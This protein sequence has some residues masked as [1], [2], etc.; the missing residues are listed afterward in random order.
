VV[1]VT[2]GLLQLVATLDTTLV[3]TS[4]P[5]IAAEFNS[6]ATVTWVGTSMLVAQATTL[7]PASRLSDIFGRKQ[8]LIASLLVFALGNL[9]CGF[10]QS[11]AWLYVARGIAGAGAG[12]INS[13]SLIV[14]S[15][16][17]S[18]RDRGKYMSYM[19]IPVALGLGLGPEL[20]GVLADHA[21]WRWAFWITVPL[22]LVNIPVIWW[23]LPLKP[24]PGSMWGKLAS[25]DWFGCGLSLAGIVLVLVPLSA[26]GATIPW[27]SA[28]AIAMLVVGG[29]VLITFL[30]AECVQYSLYV[31]CTDSRHL[32]PLPVLPLR[33]F[34]NRTVA[35]VMATMAHVG[36]VWFGAFFMDPL[37]LQNVQG[38]SAVV[39]G[40]LVLP[41]LVGQIIFMVA[42]GYAMRRWGRT[43]RIII[44]GY[45]IWTLGQGMQV[46]WGVERNV[47][48]VV[49]STFVQ[50][51][52]FGLTSQ[53]SKRKPRRSMLLTEALVLAQASCAPAD[54]AVVTGA[55]VSPRPTN[56]KQKLMAEPL[57]YGWRRGGAS[58][59]QRDRQRRL[60]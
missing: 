1:F 12:A 45:A 59:L 11:P 35:L 20:G 32:H 52:G 26:G 48:L 46:A 5:H 8:C 42:V 27:D 55:R 22:T 38:Y 23:Y 41:L 57:P 14:V 33:M 37:Y 43:K 30:F 10:A 2:I 15:D 16:V 7:S 39:A 25:V 47:P 58:S 31:T 13:L 18:L 40:A 6:G 51:I 3:S 19:G 21:S 49:A 9:L 50:G 34:R 24:V 36:I 4:L 54:R 28:A 56:T 29:I 17:V 60:H 53:T 44:A